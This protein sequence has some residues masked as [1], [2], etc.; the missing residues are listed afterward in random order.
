MQHHFCGLYAVFEG[1][2]QSLNREKLDPNRLKLPLLHWQ[3][4]DVSDLVMPTG[5]IVKRPHTAYGAI[6]SKLC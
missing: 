5:S 3:I 4:L 1:D 6:A 2:V